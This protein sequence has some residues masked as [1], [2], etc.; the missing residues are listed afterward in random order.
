MQTSGARVCLIDTLLVSPQK[1][2]IASTLEPG[3]RRKS[4]FMQRF[5]LITAL[6]LR[7]EGLVNKS[8]ETDK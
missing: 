7:I 1:H 5:R 2:V 4:G 8:A 3:I 6:A